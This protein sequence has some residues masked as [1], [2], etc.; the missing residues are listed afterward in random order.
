MF[1]DARDAAGDWREQYK[2]HLLHDLVCAGG[3]EWLEAG[4]QK[5]LRVTHGSQRLLIF[6]F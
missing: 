1:R 3:I 4:D 2:G 6:F 5:A